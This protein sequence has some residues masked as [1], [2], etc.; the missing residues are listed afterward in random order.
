VRFLIV[1]LGALG[2]IVHALPVAAALRRAR[3]DARIDWVVSARHRQILDL[4]P[5]IDR[6]IAINDRA[7]ARG[8]LPLLR[9]ISELRAEAYDVTFDLQGLIKSALIA[10]ASS[11]RRVIGFTRR[12][13]R[14]PLASLLYTETHDPHGEGL[15]SASE[16]RHVVTV[17][18][19]MLTQVGIDDPDVEFPIETLPSA[20]IADFISS[21]RKDSAGPALLNIGAAWPN[22]RW[23][24]DRFAA[25]ARAL[26]E[27]HG[28]RSV[29]LWGPGERALADA[30]VAAGAGAATAAPE[31]TIADVVTLA[32]ASKLMVSGDTGP[33]HIASAVGTPIVGIYGP[34]RPERNGPVRHD[35]LSVSRAAVCHCHHLRRCRLPRMC[36]LDIEVAEVVAAIDRRVSRLGLSGG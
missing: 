6:R 20:R 34:T 2:D 26:H 30:V 24:P 18:L 15:F 17:N 33:A 4:V 27:R 21:I 1:R 32:R 23:P 7:G 14:E 22:K 36:L 29:V 13:T 16:R 5:V 28:L 9:A 19:G 25:V 8:G 3:P 35:D 12:Y 11:A 31:T 10:R